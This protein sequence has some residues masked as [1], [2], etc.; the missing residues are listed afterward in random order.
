M[1]VDLDP[2]GGGL[3]LVLGAEDAVGLRW[4]DLAESRGRLGARALQAELPG[5][6]GLSVLSC[7]RGDLLTIPPDAAGSVLAAGRRACD[8]VVVDLPRRLDA[9][10]EEAAAA[11]ATVLLVVPAEVRAVA[12]ASRVAAGLTTI[13][14]DVRVISRRTASAGLAG[15]EVAAALGL[16]LAAEMADEPRLLERLDRGDP[17]GLDQRGPLHD[18]CAGVL[19]ELPIR[20]RV[21]A[22]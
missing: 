4:P 7:D 13:A 16:P 1:L 17:P 22:A 18:A 21:R 19:D 12:A 2:L 3:D 9:T 11:C 6:H 10:A 20:Y 5:R 14:A 15:A 8:L